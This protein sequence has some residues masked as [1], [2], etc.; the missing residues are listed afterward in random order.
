M[1]LNRTTAMPQFCFELPSALAVTLQKQAGNKQERMDKIVELA[2]LEHLGPD[3]SNEQFGPTPDLDLALLL[4]SMNSIANKAKPDLDAIVKIALQ[5][6]SR[7]RMAGES[8]P[9]ILHELLRIQAGT[10]DEERHVLKKRSTPVRHRQFE[11]VQVELPTSY[12][13]FE[14]KWIRKGDARIVNLSGG[15]ARMSSPTCF[16]QGL[17]ITLRFTLPQGP[18]EVYVHGR[19]VMSFFDGP[20]QQYSHGIVFSHVSRADQEAIV[21][22][23]DDT[24]LR[25]MRF[26]RP[27]E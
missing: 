26:L 15:G 5:F 23:V 20:T 21:R 14:E 7:S 19:I 9:S 11:R 27:S 1:E 10:P 6:H 12:S 24:L 25:N 13:I 22:H 18:R 17:P 4:A 16:E 8:L 2:L 3:P